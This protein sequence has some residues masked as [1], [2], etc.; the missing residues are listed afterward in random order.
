MEQK[1]KLKVS[2]VAF[3]TFIMAVAT[4]LSSV[5]L[6]Q[7]NL[8]SSAYAQGGAPPNPTT[9][10]YKD[11]RCKCTNGSNGYT[12]VC[13]TEVTT[14]TCTSSFSNCYDTKPTIGWPPISVFA[15]GPY[16]APPSN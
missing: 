16:P 9:K 5:D 14:E 3:A 7:L 6:N 1:S 15:C 4:T 11:A 8:V 13:Q 10:Y 12:L 2:L